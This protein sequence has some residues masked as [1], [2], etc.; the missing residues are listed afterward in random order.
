MG[1]KIALGDKCYIFIWPFFI[2]GEFLVDS[3]S[4]FFD[5]LLA[6]FLSFVFPFG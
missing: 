5:H 3:S 2:S 6:K 1:G 4:F